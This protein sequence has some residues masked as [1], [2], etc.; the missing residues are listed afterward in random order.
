MDLAVELLVR[1]VTLDFGDCE[2]GSAAFL[3][4][5]MLVEDVSI[6][7]ESVS[8]ISI[9]ASV[10][11]RQAIGTSSDTSRRRGVL[12]RLCEGDELDSLVIGTVRDKL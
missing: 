3:R 5:P 2:R 4:L 12:S 7:Q 1:L 10:V 9:R 6:S 11:R 8:D